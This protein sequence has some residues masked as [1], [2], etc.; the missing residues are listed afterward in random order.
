MFAMTPIRPQIETKAMVPKAK[1]D[2]LE[3]CV[4]TLR[5]RTSMELFEKARATKSRIRLV[6]KF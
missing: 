1:T 6:R 5:I 4:K 3:F 2:T